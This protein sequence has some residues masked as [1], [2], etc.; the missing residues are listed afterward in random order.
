MAEA[1]RSSTDPRGRVKGL[2]IREV[3]RF[4]KDEVGGARVVEL[5]RGMPPEWVGRLDLSAEGL[6]MLPATWYPMSM[7]HALLDGLLVGIDP[8]DRS[9]AAR[10][11]ARAVTAATLQGVHKNFFDLFGTPELYA[12]YAQKVW[13]TYFDRGAFEVEFQG[14]K[15]VTAVVR[16][17]SGHHIFL[18]ETFIEVTGLTFEKMGLKD[19]RAAR[20]SCV[21]GGAAACTAVVA[22]EEGRVSRP[23]INPR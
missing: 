16:D 13:G 7:I 10:G 5:M 6:G 8:C 23:S 22:W 14:P 12:R 15:R 17:W 11:A 2:V 20:V 21:S 4:L 3:L 18:C 19:V 9:S 1:P